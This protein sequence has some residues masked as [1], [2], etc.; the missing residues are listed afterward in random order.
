M[1]GEKIIFSFGWNELLLVM[2]KV[3]K[4]LLFLVF[5]IICIGIMLIEWYIRKIKMNFELGKGF[6]CNYVM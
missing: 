1:N 6:F 4:L 5:L 2:M 3:R